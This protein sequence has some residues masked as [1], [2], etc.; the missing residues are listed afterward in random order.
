MKPKE[1]LDFSQ[2]KVLKSYL[3]EGCKCRGSSTIIETGNGDIVDQYVRFCK[4]ADEERKRHGRTG[5]AIEETLRP[6]YRGKRVSAIFEDTPKGVVE[7]MVTSFDQEKIMEIHDYHIAEAARQNGLQ[8]GRAEG[9]E[10]RRYQ[11]SGMPPFDV[12]YWPHKL[13]SEEPLTIME[14]IFTIR[15]KSFN[16]VSTDYTAIDFCCFENALYSPDSN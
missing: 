7:I 8:K 9:V 11:S 16:S 5:R 3:I 4:I 1:A 12:I 14:R 6:V 15:L 13:Y 2:Q 10:N